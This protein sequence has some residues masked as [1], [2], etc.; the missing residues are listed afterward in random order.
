VFTYEMVKDDNHLREFVMKDH[1]FTS[2]EAAKHFYAASV[3]MYNSSCPPLS[4]EESLAASR[5]AI[6]QFQKSLEI[7]PN[8]SAMFLCGY[9]LEDKKIGTTP[10]EFVTFLKK[11]RNK[12]KRYGGIFDY[13]I[14]EYEKGE[15]L[16][17]RK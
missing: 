11:W 1:G 2:V 9:L 3:V 6:D 4:M 13:A 17:Q 15:G 10:E 8:D 14:K 12:A 16:L 5:Y 7:E